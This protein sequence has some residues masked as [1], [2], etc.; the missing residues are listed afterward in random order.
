VFTPLFVMF[1]T[2]LLLSTTEQRS[3]CQAVYFPLLILSRASGTKALNTI[4]SA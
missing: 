1:A 2:A 4:A 3:L